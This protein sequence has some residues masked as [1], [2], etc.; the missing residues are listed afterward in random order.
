MKSIAIVSTLAAIMAVVGF[1]IGI[2]VHGTALAALLPAVAGGLGG[3][4]IGY[5][6]LDVTRR[7]RGRRPPR[8]TPAGVVCE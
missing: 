6:C 3:A 8:L 4:G 5:A 7:L 1:C 2:T